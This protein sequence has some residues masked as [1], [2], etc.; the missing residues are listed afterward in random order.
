[1]EP[2]SGLSKLKFLGAI[3]KI[4]YGCFFDALLMKHCSLSI[5]TSTLCFK[6]NRSSLNKPFFHFRVDVQ[7]SVVSIV[8]NK[9][10][11]FA[12]HGLRIYPIEL[13]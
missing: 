12:F 5:N 11:G 3:A 8:L 10:G 1:M 9:R 2:K 4:V 6:I 7:C 13:R